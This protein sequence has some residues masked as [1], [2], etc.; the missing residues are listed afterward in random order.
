MAIVWDLIGIILLLAIIIHIFSWVIICATISMQSKIEARMRAE[1][2]Q[3][4]H[5]LLEWWSNPR[6]S[7]LDSLKTLSIRAML[8]TGALF[9]I[10]GII[11]YLTQSGGE[12][13]GRFEDY[14]SG[15]E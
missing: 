7:R 1:V 14:C 2:P 8:L 12:C 11:G 10:V 3:S 9:L 4:E 5:N 6:W 13:Y 15:F